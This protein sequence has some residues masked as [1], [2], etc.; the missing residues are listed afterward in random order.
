MIANKLIALFI[1]CM[2][3]FI[4]MISTGYTDDNNKKRR[5]KKTVLTTM[6]IPDTPT[7]H[8]EIINLESY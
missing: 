2:T 7:T 8:Y 5:V 1:A 6:S 3:I 4:L